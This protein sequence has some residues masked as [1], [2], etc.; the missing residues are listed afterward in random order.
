MICALTVGIRA[1]PTAK[2]ASKEQNAW[3]IDSEE[4]LKIKDVV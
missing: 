2:E 1:A 3:P 4:L